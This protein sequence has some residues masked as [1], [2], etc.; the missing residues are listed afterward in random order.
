MENN[1][2]RLRGSKQRMCP[3]KGCGYEIIRVKPNAEHSINIIIT[4]TGIVNLNQ[5]ACMSHSLTPFSIQV[6]N[7]VKSC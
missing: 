3:E 6:A 1:R 2:N 5:L 7:C 4:L